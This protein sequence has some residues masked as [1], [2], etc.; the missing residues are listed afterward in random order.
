MDSPKHREFWDAFLELIRPK[1]KV[2]FDERRA[3]MYT[4]APTEAKY[5]DTTWSNQW[6]ERCWT[7]DITNPLRTTN[8]VLCGRIS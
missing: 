5:I 8:D 1:T 3:F 7:S 4:L 2:E 6:K